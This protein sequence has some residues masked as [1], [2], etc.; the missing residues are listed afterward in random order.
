MAE[1]QLGA[2]G[3]ILT[4]IAGPGSR[5]RIP[6]GFNPSRRAQGRYST[7]GHLEPSAH[8]H[9]ASLLEVVGQAGLGHAA[10]VVRGL[11]IVAS[12]GIVYGHVEADE[13]GIVLSFDNLAVC[14]E[15]PGNENVLH[16]GFD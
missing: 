8:G 12:L 11:F 10:V 15:I 4:T 13:L 2:G 1:L 7:G 14:G 3:L 9:V 6:A 16:N 5:W